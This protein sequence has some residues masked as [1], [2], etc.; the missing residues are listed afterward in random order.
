MAYRGR[1]Q[2]DLYEHSQTYAASSAEPRVN[3]NPAN[4]GQ[5]I[6]TG[7]I[8]GAAATWVMTQYQVNSKK[9]MQKVQGQQQQQSGGGEQQQQSG[10]QNPTVAVADENGETESFATA[11]EV[12]MARDLRPPR[13]A[14]PTPAG[15]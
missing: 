13:I 14:V 6:L 12:P 15:R 4:F 11:V 5:R 9:L 7:A 8:A 3:S 1:T 2:H 10:S